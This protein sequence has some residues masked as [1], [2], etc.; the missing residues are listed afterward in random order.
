[1]KFCV[2]QLR[3]AEKRYAKFQNHPRET[4]STMVFSSFTLSYCN[5]SHFFPNGFGKGNLS[6]RQSTLLFVSAMKWLQTDTPQLKNPF[7]ISTLIILLGFRKKLH[8]TA[9]LTYCRFRLHL[10]LVLYFLT[11]VLN[12]KLVLYFRQQD[13]AEERYKIFAN[14]L[15]NCLPN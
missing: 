15:I 12:F 1:M 8:L 10:M 5:I 2:R 7:G 9:V 3:Q 4:N 6:V 14:A 13:K 11:L